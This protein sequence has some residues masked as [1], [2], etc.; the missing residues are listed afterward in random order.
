MYN[1]EHSSF[2]EL[3]KKDKGYTVHMRNIQI[4][5]TEMFKAKYNLDPHLLQGIFEANSYQGPTLRN[6]KYFSLPNE[7]V[8]E[9]G[10]NVMGTTS[11]GNPGTG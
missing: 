2:E 9:S 5:L 11:K 1:D 3:L 8:T 7:I 4:L 6:T 10:C